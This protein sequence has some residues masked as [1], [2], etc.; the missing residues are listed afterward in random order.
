MSLR[1]PVR[2]YYQIPQEKHAGVE[3]A[4]Q[5]YIQLLFYFQNDVMEYKALLFIFCFKTTLTPKS[6]CLTLLISQGAVQITWLTV[7][8]FIKC[9][10]RPNSFPQSLLF[11]VELWLERTLH[12]LWWKH[13]LLFEGVVPISVSKRGDNSSNICGV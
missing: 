11:Y 3:E 12:G 8:R 2:L 6:E 7:C 1:I 13:Q 9:H 5:I 10:L 4:G